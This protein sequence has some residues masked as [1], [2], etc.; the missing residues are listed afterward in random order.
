MTAEFNHLQM[1]EILAVGDILSSWRT[2]HIISGLQFLPDLKIE[3]IVDLTPNEKWSSDGNS[4]EAD[5]MLSFHKHDRM[6]ANFLVDR[7]HYY[8]PQARISFPEEAKVRHSLLDNARLFVPLLSC[9]FTATAELTE[10]LNTALCRQRFGNKLV[11]FPV[12]LEPLP[13][14]PSYFH[15][16]WSLISCEDKVWEN[17]HTLAKITTDELVIPTAQ[18]C[19]DYAARMISLILLSPGLFHG[20]FKTLLSIRELQ[21]TTL[22]FRAKLPANLIGYNPLY[23][24][25]TKSGHYT[26]EVKKD[27][28]H[29]VSGPRGT[30]E[31]ASDRKAGSIA[32]IQEAPENIVAHVYGEKPALPSTEL[33]AP[34]EESRKVPKQPS[35]NAEETI[36]DQTDERSG[37]GS[38]NHVMKDTNPLLQR[39][40]EKID[41]NVENSSS[42][43]VEGKSDKNLAKYRVVGSI[44]CC[45][46]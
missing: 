10:E 5:I 30:A 25:E 12:A 44:A 9:S 19:L 40:V 41:A 31:T 38:L 8:L 22:R 16:I 46:S 1:E 34:M 23:F 21:D 15:L 13:S 27:V 17:Y 36:L 42:S 6:M 3:D 7:L 33:S 24:E 39:T 28:C 37:T 2:E 14:T 29:S 45:V 32:P 43:K 4:N 35:E 20:S 18:R 11:L 26:S